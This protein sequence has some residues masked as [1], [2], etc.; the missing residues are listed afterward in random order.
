MTIR[1]RNVLKF[2]TGGSFDLDAWIKANPEYYKWYS[3]LYPNAPILQGNPLKQRNDNWNK[4]QLS[5]SHYTTDDLRRSAYNN[6]LYTNDYNARQEDLIRWGESQQDFGTISDQE[7]VDRYNQQAQRIRD[8]REAPQTYNRT[9]YRGTNRDFRGM[10]YNRSKQGTN[11]PLYNIGYQDN[12]E[13]IEGTSTWQRRMDRYEKE[14]ENDTPEGQANRT[15]YITRPDGTKIKVYKK[16]NGDIGLFPNNGT[17][18]NP[19]D[20]AN[21]QAGIQARHDQ[22]GN[23]IDWKQIGANFQKMMPN[24][25][26]DIRL[27]MGL[28]AN[29]RILREKLKGIRPNLQDTYYT[30]RQV[31]GDEGTKQAYY[32]R[33]AQGQT[34]AAQP[35]TSDADRQVAYEMEAKRE[36]DELRARGDLADNQEI[37]RTSDESNQHEWANTQRATDVA[38]ANAIQ[39]NAANAARQDLLAQ[40]VS[41][42]N[43]S[44]DNFLK[45]REYRIRERDAEE[46]MMEDQIFAMQAKDQLEDDEELLQAKKKLTDL[47]NKHTDKDGNVDLTNSEIQEAKR[48]YR[49]LM[50]Q[51]TAEYYQTLLNYRRQS[52]PLFPFSAK[53]GTKLTYKTKRSDNLLY[54]SARDTVEHFRKMSKMSDDS[55]QR[56]RPKSQI[57]LIPHPRKMQ[58]GGVAPFTVF[59]PVAMGGER[60]T[61]QTSSS[62]FD[63]AKG[64]SSKKDDSAKEKL[65]FVKSLFK[66]I[67]GLP[68]DVNYTYKAFK[69]VFDQAELFGTEIS[70]DDLAGMYLKAMNQLNNVKFSKEIFDKAKA[71]ATSK[72]AL[73]EFAVSA[74]GRLV[75]QD[76]ESGKI[77]LGTL[78]DAKEKGL[79][80]L[81]NN[82]LLN[83][84][85]YSPDMLLGKGDQYME[86]VSNGV[87]M[88]KIA[89]FLKNQLPHIGN[90]EE[91]LEGYTKQ[92]SVNIKAGIQLLKDA[93]AGEYKWSQYSKQQQK[94]AEMAI[95]YLI[96]ILPKNMK[97]ILQV[98]AQMQGT[99]LK[100][101]VAALVGS[102]ISSSSKL[103]WDAVTGK[104]AKGKN[105]DSEGLDKINSNPLMAIQREIGGSPI[106]YSL[107]TRDSNTKMSVDGTYYSSLP[108]ITED[109][110]VNQMLNV[111]GIGGIVTN[112]RGITFGDQQISPED[113]SQ[114]MYS[115]NGGVVATLPCKIVN[116]VKQINLDIV[117]AYE[118]AEQKVLQRISDRQSPEFAQ[119]LG[120]E[121]KNMHLD[122]LL[123]SKGLPNKNMFA[124]FLLVEGYTSDRIKLKTDSQ[125]IEKV[126]DPSPELEARMS[127]ALSTDKKKS[128]YSLDVKD[129]WTIFEGGWDDIYRGMI[130]I[131]LNNNPNAAVNS[132]GG[133]VKVDQ[134]TELEEKYQIFNKSSK[135]NSDNS[136]Q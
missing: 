40:K 15:F 51:K 36:A 44:W 10:F 125:Y 57:K 35:M 21:P 60:T 63:L 104:G 122:S 26:E 86:I 12:I 121:L 92:D 82:Q 9:G 74:D 103:E 39:L 108:K 106:N 17:P 20:P 52:R 1:P 118:R 3:N 109:M 45:S 135:F 32:T 107:I 72:E 96:G 46:R 76:M 78:T 6:Y 25:L 128:N 69:N 115:N 37:R 132:W 81:T 80:P 47:V 97:T 62:L 84:R 136:L 111:S 41:A 93:P 112:K 77:T 13:D 61:S 123:D 30:H 113:L 50:S 48:A 53:E 73:N 90:I 5:S 134:A 42:D 38:N 27:G 88:T 101:M 2:Q 66:E 49:R 91:A 70:S 8:A 89:E 127:Q 83:L 120:K 28:N 71:E 68:I 18:A 75:L 116:G 23:P 54:K 11:H 100:D 130:F 7:F 55:T 102:T 124:Q 117:P 34:R 98:N 24:L 110:S 119:E 31:V 99:N 133:N 4:Q 129:H 95:G 59:T 105:G 29:E 56:S 94:Q 14:F 126:T 67:N 87:G 16:A 79:N 33:A 64:A 114:I 131:P 22:Y 85:A 65:D 58:Q 43:S 19:N